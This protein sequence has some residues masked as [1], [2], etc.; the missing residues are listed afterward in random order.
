MVECE[1]IMP[2][3]LVWPTNLCCW[4]WWH[5]GSETCRSWHL[6]WSVFCDLFYFIII[7]V[8]CCFLKMLIYVIKVCNIYMWMCNG[9]TRVESYL[10]RVLLCVIYLCNNLL[11]KNTGMTLLMVQNHPFYDLLTFYFDIVMYTPEFWME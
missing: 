5:L 2:E 9:F 6:I 1:W 4:R 3:I 11:H 10:A 7:G 8:F